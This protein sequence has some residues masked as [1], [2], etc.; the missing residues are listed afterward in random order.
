M[1]PV[2][3]IQEI[4]IRS[5]NLNGES[6]LPSI[7]PMVNVQTQRSIKLDE[8]DEIF[9]DL[10]KIKTIYPYK[11]QD[12]YDRTLQDKKYRAVV[13]ENQYLK[14]IFLPELGGRLWSLFD[15]KAGR[16]LLYVNDCIRFCN[17][18]LCNAWISG[19]VEWNIGMIG[20]SPFTCSP[21]FAAVLEASDGTPILRMY[22]YE[23]IRNVTYQMDFSLPEWSEMLLCRMRIVNLNDRTI[24][25]YWWSNIAVPQTKHTRVIV[26]AESAYFSS[27]SVISKTSIPYR[28]GKDVTYPVNTECAMDYFY[29]ILDNRRKYI[30]AL[31]R[32]GYGLIQTSTRRLRGRKLFVWGQCQGGHTWQRFLTDKAGD[33][34]EIQ[35]GLGRTQYECIPMP[36]SSAWEWV[37]A[38]GAMSADPK[39]VHNDW[40]AARNEVERRLESKL[41]EEWLEEYLL[42]SKA[43]YVFKKG[44]VFQCGSGFGAL[45][46]K[47]RELLGQKSVSEHLDFGEVQSAQQ[48]WLLLL[49]QGRLPIPSTNKAPAS[50]M[51]GDHWYE[52][53]T[54]A[55]GPEDSNWY[56]WYHKGMMQIS[57]QE[58]E[59][60]IESLNNSIKIEP[61]SWAYYGLAA[62]YYSIGDLPA[63]ADSIKLAYKLNPSDLSLAKDTFRI[64]SEN[65]QFQEIIDIYNEMDEELQRVGKLK[66]YLANSYAHLGQIEK[67]EGILFENGGLIIPDIREGEV[68]ITDL[69]LYIE[70]QKSKRQNKPFD[71]NSAEIP[72]NLDFRAV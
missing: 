40:D 16:E 31:D 59:K 64:L 12:L 2:L 13:L 45:E 9:F 10:G 58:Y 51:V 36:P 68:M 49:E 28:S 47:R 48:D 69:W 60:A 53:L 19:G 65:G 14:A 52:L 39:A 72:P 5:A 21:L 67:A 57:R 38:Y 56:A 42:S 61:S 26:P 50:Y 62:C 66:Y 17:L 23:R 4:S 46:N 70:A 18:A 44:A 32:D 37:E 29:K 6:L 35:A 8:D 1:K 15:K 3:E 54:A 22:E 41:N 27:P 11:Q 55:H 30:A 33:Y 34:A 63:G 71:I 43:D 7:L 20:H 25:M 24:P